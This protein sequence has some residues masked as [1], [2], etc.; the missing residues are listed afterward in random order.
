ME[1][2]L[3]AMLVQ[4][5]FRRLLRAPSKDRRLRAMRYSIPSGVYSERHLWREDCEPCG[6]AYLQAFTPSA[7]YG[8]KTASRAVQHTYRRLLRA[9]SMERRLRAVRYS[10]PSGVYSERHLRREDCESCGTAYLQAFT[11]SA[12]YGEKTAS[13]A[14]QHNF[15]RLF[16]A[17]FMERRLRVMRYSIPSGVYSERH[18]WREDCESCGTA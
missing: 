4:H 8:E 17:P 7:I 10:I 14:V 12:I 15:R 16:R 3:R 1:R 2:R 13:H 11:P 9:P 6:T 5:T 18:L